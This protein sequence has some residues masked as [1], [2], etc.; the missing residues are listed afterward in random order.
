MPAMTSSTAQDGRCWRRSSVVRGKLMAA[1]HA[2]ASSAAV[3][4]GPPMPGIGPREKVLSVGL[5]TMVPICGRRADA[6]CA[7][8]ESVSG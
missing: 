2:W 6:I 3:S 1:A 8:R 4:K 7:C 5:R